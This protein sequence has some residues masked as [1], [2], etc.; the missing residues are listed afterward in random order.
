[1]KKTI[2][3]YLMFN[4]PQNVFAVMSRK[5]N[6]FAPGLQANDLAD[7]I[8]T[9]SEKKEVEAKVWDSSAAVDKALQYVP[10][11]Y[12]YHVNRLMTNNVLYT[13]NSGL[14]SIVMY[15]LQGA[16]LLSL[17]EFLPNCIAA[18][19]EIMNLELLTRAFVEL[20]ERRKVVE[21]RP[22]PE[23]LVSLL[24]K[25]KDMVFTASPFQFRNYGRI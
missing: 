7:A 24:T 2:S 11:L 3:S 12:L 15:E 17:F 6:G 10:Y 13:R 21:S 8:G 9:V 4:R 23:P 14:K 16:S 25:R 18:A 22:H 1:M 19:L 20:K 5:E